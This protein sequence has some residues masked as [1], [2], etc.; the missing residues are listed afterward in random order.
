[1]NDSRYANVRAQ[2]QNLGAIKEG[3]N[4]RIQERTIWDTILVPANTAL[5]TQDLFRSSNKTAQYQNFAFPD[6]ANGY[7]FQYARIRHNLQF[8][9]TTAGQ[10]DWYTDYFN[11]FSTINWVASNIAIPP[12]TVGQLNPVEVYQDWNSALT[13]PGFDNFQK[14]KTW[15]WYELSDPIV[16]G[17]GDQISVQFVPAA[18]LST[19]AS[20]TAASTPYAPFNGVNANCYIR[21]EYTGYMYSEIR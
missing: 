11:T 9:V 4:V 21:V 6:T 14:Q 15:D 10:Q 7:L 13:T 3:A 17:A 2:L 12:Y 19:I 5:T 20:F 8:A 1:M 18:S 16:T